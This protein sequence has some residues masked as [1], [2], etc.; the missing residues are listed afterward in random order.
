METEADYYEILDKGGTHFQ[1]HSLL[2]HL[3]EK[4]AERREI[5]RK[6]YCCLAMDHCTFALDSN[7]AV[8]EAIIDFVADD[9]VGM[10]SKVAQRNGLCAN[11]HQ[12]A[13]SLREV[14]KRYAQEY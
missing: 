1:R 4:L 5:A 3:V 6:E 13:V 10:V 12:C 9:I 14:L 11:M 7:D 8:R 2:F